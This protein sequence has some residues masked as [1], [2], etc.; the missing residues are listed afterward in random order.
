M[1]PPSPL[2]SLLDRS[3]GR[4]LPLP[5]ALEHWYGALRFPRPKER[6]YVVANFVSTLDGVVAFP[7]PRGGGSEISGGNPDDRILMGL[8]RAAADAV[9]VGAGTLRSVPRHVWTPGGIF[10]PLQSEYG[11]LRRGLGKPSLPINV[12]VTASGK[13]DLTLPVFRTQG[14][15]AFV[16]STRSGSKSLRRHDP[17]GQV[18]VQ[19]SR[20]VT[21]VSAAAICQ[22]VQER[23]PR[24]DLILVEGGPHLLGEFLSEGLLDEL[25]L[26]LAPQLA[27]RT[28]DQARLGLVEG[29]SFAPDHP[30]WGS[31]LSAKRSGDHLF[32]RYGV[33]QRR[34]SPKHS[35]HSRS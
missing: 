5:P 24:A 6:P 18:S 35:T 19:D 4:N 21:K 13:L 16:V 20:G 22:A 30:L 23:L 2:H 17:A 26:T 11:A 32:L 29:R 33:S 9:V 27:G 12:V 15:H 3:R 34:T 1:R 10:P 25:F 14:L 8:L 28:R 7:G 31:L